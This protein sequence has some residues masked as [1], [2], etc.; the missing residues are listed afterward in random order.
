M[1]KKRKKTVPKPPPTKRELSKWQRQMQIRRIIIIA[2]V[3]LLAGIVSWVLHGVYKDRF[4]P[5]RE[6]VIEV[7]DVSFAMRYYVDTLDAYTRDETEPLM[8]QYMASMMADMIIDVEVMKQYAQK[9]LGIEVTS[10]EIEAR[11]QEEGWPEGEI[12]RDIV[13]S[14]LLREELEEYFDSQL[15]DTMEQAHVRVML[16]ESEEVSDEVIAEIEGGANFTALVDDFSCHPQIKGDLGWLPRQLMPN[17]I[18]EEA[19]FNVTVGEISEPIS[20]RT[21]VKNIGYWLIEVT[22]EEGDEIEARAMLLG[23]KAE[24]ERVKAE[25]VTGNFT[26]LAAQYSQHPSAAEGGELGWLK[27]GDMGSNAFDDVAFNLTPN[28]VSEPVK[29]GAVPTTGGYWIVEVLDRDDE[30]ELAGET[31]EELMYMRWTEWLEEQKEKSTIQN[32][33]DEAKISWAVDRVLRGR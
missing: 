21:A 27:K 1:A 8:I 31:R 22:D 25:L 4:G 14:V 16:V 9:E 2:A 18:I 13:H 12:Y 30:R 33:L 11:R 6:V 17:T 5:L 7:N 28:A 3:V 24:A 10:Q 29:D 26:A 32:R 19:A 23:S 15:P 20:D